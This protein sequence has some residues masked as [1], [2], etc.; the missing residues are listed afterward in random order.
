MSKKASDIL[1]R[2]KEVAARERAKPLEEPSIT[3]PSQESTEI[4]VEDP[5]HPSKPRRKE[6]VR[7]T[8]DLDPE[9]HRF[10]KVYAAQ[11]GI[12]VSEV[13]RGLFER[14]RQANIDG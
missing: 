13:V 6:T 7:I 3:S 9:L 8:V 11:R 10:L 14:L 12:T 5:I 1:S 4:P 2:M